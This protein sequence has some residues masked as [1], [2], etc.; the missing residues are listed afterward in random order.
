MKKEEIV[1]Q[2]FLRGLRYTVLLLFTIF[3]WQYAVFRLPQFSI[4][5]FPIFIG[6]VGTIAFSYYSITFERKKPR[7]L[8]L[9]WFFV[10]CAGAVFLFYLAIEMDNGN[11]PLNF[12]P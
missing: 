7:L 11:N 2:R 9:L 8:H 5:I 10:M 1:H 3:L 12:P 6:I 4:F